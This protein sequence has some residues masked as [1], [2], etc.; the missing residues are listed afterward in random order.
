ME[1]DAE[2]DVKIEKMKADVSKIVDGL[3]ELR[4]EFRFCVDE[5]SQAIS[6]IREQVKKMKIIGGN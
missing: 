3:A 6:K 2:V 4:G 1:K 5:L